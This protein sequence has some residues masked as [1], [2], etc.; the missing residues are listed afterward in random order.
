MEKNSR[1]FFFEFK[2]E[3]DTSDELDESEMK[4]R[5]RIQ[6]W[7]KY[8]QEHN[9]PVLIGEMNKIQ[10]SRLRKFEEPY[11]AYFITYA[12]GTSFSDDILYELQMELMQF[13]KGD[14]EFPLVMVEND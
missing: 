10:G 5:E 7:V 4:I 2:I 11:M 9:L 6:S 3:G 8:R 14:G 12:G 13:V 1:G